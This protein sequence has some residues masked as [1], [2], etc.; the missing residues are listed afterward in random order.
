MSIAARIKEPAKPSM[1]G[2][3]CSIGHLLKTLDADEAKA[4]T[5]MLYD[6]NWNAGQVYEA[7]RE[8]GYT[9]GR[10]SVNRHRGG[11]CRCVKDKR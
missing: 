10:Q 9:V 4:L 6:L 5:V 1:N 11:R 7:L 8:E 2:M 3:P